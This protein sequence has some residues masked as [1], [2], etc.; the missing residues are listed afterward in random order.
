MSF[1]YENTINLIILSLSLSTANGVKS[2]LMYTQ[3]EVECTGSV[4]AV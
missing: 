1:F 2:F 3:T 4:A